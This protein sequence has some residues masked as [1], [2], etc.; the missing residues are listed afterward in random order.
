M[1]I[2]CLSF[3][4]NQLLYLLFLI[5]WQLILTSFTPLVWIW[6]KVHLSFIFRSQLITQSDELNR[7]FVLLNCRLESK[8]WVLSRCLYWIGKPTS[9]IILVFV[10]L[11]NVTGWLWLVL[12]LFRKCAIKNNTLVSMFI[13]FTVLNLIVN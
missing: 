7:Q 6:L 3:I 1:Y 2:S 4:F 5:G 11:F 12:L 9:G 8:C 10:R 13:V